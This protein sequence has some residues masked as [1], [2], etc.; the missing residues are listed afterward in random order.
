MT[1]ERIE[2]LEKMGFDFTPLE[3][4]LSQ[5]N[6]ESKTQQ[7]WDAKFADLERYKALHGD[8]LVSCL[9][10][11]TVSSSTIIDSSLSFERLFSSLRVC[12][13]DASY[14][15]HPPILS[16]QL[17]NWVRR[18]RKLYNRIGRDGFPP[19]RLARLDAIG[20]DFDPVRSGTSMAKKR[21]KMFP[22]VNANW[23]KHYNTLKRFKDLHGHLVIGPNTKGWAGLYHWVH[24]QRKEYKKF[25]AGEESTLMHEQWI[26]KLNNLGFNWAPMASENYSTSVL[27]RH[28]E[29]YNEVWN[30]HYQ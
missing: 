13:N 11:E 26:T 1:E 7:Q 23:E 3:S 22:R 15:I 27:R 10:E 17:G 28:S 19:E 12:R 21:A 25:Q 5:K 16:T 9:A 8:C 29:H 14:S 24:V 18:Q 6:R 2:T 30:R 4:G 20:F